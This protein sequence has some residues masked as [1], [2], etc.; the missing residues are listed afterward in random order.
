MT[1]SS[2]FAVLLFA[3]PALAAGGHHKAP[4]LDIGNRLELMVDDYLIDSMTGDVRLELQTPNSGGKVL[5]FDRPWEGTTCFYISVVHGD[6]LYRLYYRGHSDPSYAVP[7]L[8]EP[9]ETMIP[10]HPEVTCY[11]ESRDGRTW[12]KP[13]LGLVEYDGSKENNIIWDGFGNHNFMV[14]LDTNPKTPPQER[15]K[16]LASGHPNR[17]LKRMVG[18]VSPDGIHWKPIREE[19]ILTQ[20][21]TDWGGDGDPLG[22]VQKR[23]R[24]L[25]PRLVSTPSRWFRRTPDA[26]DPGHRA[27]HLARFSELERTGGHR[28]G[29]GSP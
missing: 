25:S 16:A 27:R 5:D 26:H 4:A 17:P 1:K 21:P 9:G 13:S 19:P 3:T 24:R 12:I 10:E 15:Y 23:I 2:L 28:L 29:R 22:R 6:G 7:S 8:L 20:L 11:A 14:F 18:M